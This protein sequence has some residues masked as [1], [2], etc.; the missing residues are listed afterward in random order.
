VSKWA[1][2]TVTDKQG[3]RY[4]LDV[5]AN[6]SYDAAHLYLTLRSSESCL[7]D[8]EA[9]PSTLFEVSTEGKVLYVEG[10][11]LKKWIE[12]RRI[13]WKGPRGHLFSQRPTLD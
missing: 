13:D 7:R 8:T 11:K 5:N 3:R 10:Q 12:R 9:G 4:S 2:V 6:S 1:T